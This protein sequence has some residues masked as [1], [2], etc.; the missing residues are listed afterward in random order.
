MS[1]DSGAGARWSQSHPLRNS[2]FVKSFATLESVAASSSFVPTV[3][4]TIGTAARTAASFPALNSAALPAA[5]TARVRKGAMT[6]V[7]G[8]ESTAGARLSEPAPRLKK[9]LWIR[10]QIRHSLPALSPRHPSPRRSRRHGGPFFP[11]PD[12]SSA[13][14]VDGSG[15]FSILLLNPGET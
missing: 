12:E 10:L 8:S 1:N 14:S 2:L 5:D 11:H 3:I 9:P 4:A 13:I 15:V 6:G 7:T